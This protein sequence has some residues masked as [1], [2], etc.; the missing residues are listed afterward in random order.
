[1]AKPAYKVVAFSMERWRATAE[2]RRTYGGAAVTKFGVTRLDT[3]ETLYITAYGKTP[4][5]RKTNAMNEA[6]YRWAK[7]SPAVIDSVVKS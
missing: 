4:G 2:E 6:R 7:E 5:E 3:N 1:M